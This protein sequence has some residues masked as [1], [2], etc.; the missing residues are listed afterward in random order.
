MLLK[1]WNGLALYTTRFV[2]NACVP[3]LKYRT[4]SPLVA[5]DVEM[6]GRDLW[7]KERKERHADCKG[8]PNG[9][10]PEGCCKK[11]FISSRHFF[12]NR[13]DWLYARTESYSRLRLNFHRRIAIIL[14]RLRSSSSLFLFG[15]N[16]LIYLNKWLAITKG[17]V[18]NADNNIQSNWSRN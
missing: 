2:R 18:F 4:G 10:A 17:K 11:R 9:N 8:R 14:D 13:V 1:I 3:L 5:V 12:F 16:G 6:T 15:E 7:E